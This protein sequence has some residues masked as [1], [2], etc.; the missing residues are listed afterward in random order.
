M[1]KLSNFILL[2]FQ[3]ASQPSL[4]ETISSLRLEILDSWN[5]L[6]RS[7]IH[8]SVMRI[9]ASGSVFKALRFDRLIQSEGYASR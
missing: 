7:L 6:L 5:E 2:Q 9:K 1:R 3:Q 8:R 4:I